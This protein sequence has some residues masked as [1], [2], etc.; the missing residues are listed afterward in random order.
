M[1]NVN[2]RF[3][4]NPVSTD[5]SRST[6]R[7]HWTHLTTMNAGKLY[8]VS[9]LEVLPGDTF[10]MDT[11]VLARMSTPIYPVMDDAYLDLY[12]FFVPNRLV[13][14]HWKNFM[15]ENEDSAWVS[16]IDYEVPQ[17]KYVPSEAKDTNVDYMGLPVGKLWSQAEEAFARDIGQISVN[18]MPLRALRLIWNEWFRD[19]NV[20]APKL[21]NTGDMETDQT[22][23]DLYPVAKYHDYFTSVL[24]A[25]QKGPAVPLPLT[26]NAPVFTGDENLG[27]NTQ[28][29]PLWLSALGADFD[30]GNYY[31]LTVSSNSGYIGTESHATGLNLSDGY[32]VDG[33]TYPDS[34]V[35]VYVRNAYA[36]LGKVTAATVNQLRQ[37][38]Q[39]QKLYERDARGGS[40]YIEQIRAHFGVISPDARMQRPEFLGG[41]RT[42]INMTQVAQTSAS[43]GTSPQGNMAA[44]S[45]TRASENSYT[46]SFTEHGFVI[47]VACIRTHQSYQNGINRLW[48]RK[49]RLDYYYPVFAN[50]GEQVVLNKEIYAQGT[51]EDDEVFGYQE[52][53]AEY[54]YTPSTI[55]GAFRSNYEG[56]SLDSWHYGADFHELPRYSEAFIYDSEV[57]VERTL[58]VESELAPQFIVDFSFVNKATR[59]MPMYSIPGLIDHH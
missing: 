32:N 49:G 53:W 4:Q 5:I 13:W 37:A 21:V 35:P 29:A 56:G 36:D 17:F 33:D 51:A 1:R 52:A 15:G 40:R 43:D 2:S 38:F 18:A 20:S 50:L 55:S 3:S 11:N 42:V 31:P 26:G 41:E 22:L 14:Q 10:S 34:T 16:D 24:P 25:P 27:W 44:Y 28:R 57:N 45:L 12:H 6:F 48:S 9:V 59:K 30:D 23:L 58:A 7:Q 19:Q 8:P 54:R 39:V 47:C 46:K